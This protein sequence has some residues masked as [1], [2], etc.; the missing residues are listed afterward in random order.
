MTRKN[1]LGFTQNWV[2]YT[3]Y[4]KT[5]DNQ[6]WLKRDCIIYATQNRVQSS[7]MHT[8]FVFAFYYKEKI[9]RLMKTTWPA[10]KSMNPRSLGTKRWK[11]VKCEY[12]FWYLT[13][14]HCLHITIGIL[15]LVKFLAIYAT[16]RYSNTT[17]TYSRE[18]LYFDLK[19]SQWK[20]VYDPYSQINSFRNSNLFSCLL[21]FCALSAALVLSGSSFQRR[22]A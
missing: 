7:A 21:K 16:F 1:Y 9:G 18:V 11:R 3:R 12:T 17:E 20:D 2:I 22:D 8:S 19:N 13:I 14:V 4:D 10:I 5:I 6:R 15:I